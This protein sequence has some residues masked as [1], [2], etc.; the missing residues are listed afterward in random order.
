MREK[1]KVSQKVADELKQVKEPSA[2]VFKMA[3]CDDADEYKKHFGNL[4]FDELIRALY[5]GYEIEETPEEELARI[6]QSHKVEVCM[7]D[8]H[9]N[10]GIKTALHVL[11]IKIKGINE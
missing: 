8:P 9:F 2:A 4:T 3:H 7:S 6:Y 1:V 5:I 11:G 10:R